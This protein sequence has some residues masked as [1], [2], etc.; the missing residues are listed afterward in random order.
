[1]S[2]MGQKIGNTKQYFL[3]ARRDASAGYRD[4]NVSV[5]LSVT[6]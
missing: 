5:R 3:P 1:M 2:T 4:R 6:R